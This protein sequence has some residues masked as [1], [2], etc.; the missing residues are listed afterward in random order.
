MMPVSGSIFG[1]AVKLWFSFPPYVNAPMDSTMPLQSFMRK[2]KPPSMSARSLLS[3][4]TNAVLPRG[5]PEPPGMLP[6]GIAH[7]KAGSSKVISRP[8]K[9]W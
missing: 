9:P 7:L 8:R 4:N 3:W 5:P 2:G 6:P 1:C